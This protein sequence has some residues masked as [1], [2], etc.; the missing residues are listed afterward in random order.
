MT[1]VLSLFYSI[2]LHPWLFHSK[3]EYT[4]KTMDGQDYRMVIDPY[5]GGG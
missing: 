1:C 2:K 3:V 4:Q 5:A